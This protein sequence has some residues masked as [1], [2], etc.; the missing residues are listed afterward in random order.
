MDV[1]DYVNSITDLINLSDNLDCFQSLSNISDEYDLGFYW[2]AESGC[3]NFKK[4]GNLSNYFDY[5]RYGHDIAF[6][7]SSFITLGK[8]KPLVIAVDF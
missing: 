8:R 4:L 5:E 7:Q 6:E 1:G 2:I 3:Y